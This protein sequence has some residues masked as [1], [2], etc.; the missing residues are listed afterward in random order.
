[1][2]HFSRTSKIELS[3]RYQLAPSFHANLKIR[4]PLCMT[5]TSPLF[6]TTLERKRSDIRLQQIPKYNTYFCPGLYNYVF[7]HIYKARIKISKF[8]KQRP[9]QI[10]FTPGRSTLYRIIALSHIT[11]SSLNVY[12]SNTIH[13]P[14]HV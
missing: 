4:C 1:M 8:P 2:R 6:Y 7:A 12:M 3:P 5:G 11:A 9:H 14:C 10:I 13:S